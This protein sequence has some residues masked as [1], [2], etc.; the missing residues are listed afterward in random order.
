M[1]RRTHMYSNA[2][3]KAWQ[4]N[5]RTRK[6]GVEMHTH[7]Q[8][9]LLIVSLG[10][11]LLEFRQ[12][13]CSLS[14]KGPWKFR[15]FDVRPER[16]LAITETFLLCL[17]F[18]FFSPHAMLRLMRRHSKSGYPE[19]LYRFTNYLAVANIN[20]QELAPRFFFLFFFL[21]RFDFYTV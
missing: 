20:C 2:H 9:F 3:H 16:Q 12:R 6:R 11:G 15:G 18:L 19:V 5:L 13:Y 1:F 21:P 8:L 7:A 4:V 17:S 14:S 10:C